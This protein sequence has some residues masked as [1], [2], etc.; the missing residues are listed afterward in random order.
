MIMDPFLILQQLSQLCSLNDDD[1]SSS[2]NAVNPLAALGLAVPPTI[3]TDT[4]S[5]GRP[6]R[7]VATAFENQTDLTIP[8][9]SW[10]LR[11][12]PRPTGTPGQVRVPITLVCH[13]DDQSFREIRI[14]LVRFELEADPNHL[15]AADMFTEPH[16]HLKPSPGST[17]VR[18][19]GPGVTLILSGSDLSDIDMDVT[20]A[21]GG[22]DP[23][24]PSARFE[25]PHFIIGGTGNN[26]GVACDEVLL[27]LNRNDN[28]AIVDDTLPGVDNTWR[29]LVLKELG[30]YIGDG[31]EVGTWSGMA[32]MKDFFIGFDAVDISGTFIAELVHYALENDPQVQVSIFFQNAAGQEQLETNSGDAAFEA[33]PEGRDF[34]RVRL[35][36]QPNWDSAGYRVNWVVPAGVTVEEPARRSSLN[37]GWVRVPADGQPYAFTVN[38]TDH[39]VPDQSETRQIQVAERAPGVG[40]QPLTVVFDGILD[41]P[42]FPAGQRPTN[43]LHLA[44]TPGQEATLT[45]RMGAGSGSVNATLTVPQGFTITTGAATQSATRPAGSNVYPDVQWVIR[46]PVAAPPNAQHAA[47]TLAVDDAGTIS[48]RRLRITF[49]APS[50]NGHRDFSLV[51]YTDWRA[52]AGTGQALV[53][54]RNGLAFADIAWTLESEPITSALFSDGAHDNLFN[55]ATY[56]NTEIAP[57]SYSAGT[58]RPYLGSDN[59]LYKLTGSVGAAPLTTPDRTPL[60]IGEPHNS[61]LINNPPQEIADFLGSL[62]S[63]DPYQ[64]SDG[65]TVRTIQ[66]HYDCWQ[67]QPPNEPGDCATEGPE[68]DG[69]RIEFPGDVN[70]EQAL[71]FAALFRAIDAHRDE[72]EAIGLF[73]G[74]SIEGSFTHNLNLAQNRV[75]AV[76]GALTNP[77][78]PLVDAMANLPGADSYTITPTVTAAIAALAPAGIIPK[79]FGE[80]R[81]KSPIDPAD[82]RVFAIF[83]LKGVP[84]TQEIVHTEYFVTLPGAPQP[85]ETPPTPQKKLQEHPF[86]HSIFRL[87]HVEV[88]LLRN[89]LV[90]LQIR[91]KLDLEAFNE[92]D[93][94]SLS[95]MRSRS[96]NDLDGVTTFFLEMKRNPE[97]QPGEPE[98][99]WEFVVLSDPGDVDGLTLLKKP[100]NETAVDIIGPPAIVTPALTA[101]RGGRIGISA[102]IAGV[103]VGAVLSAAGIIDAQVIVWRGIRFK[104]R[105]GSFDSQGI[106]LAVDYTVRYNIDANLGQMGNSPAMSNLPRLTTDPQ[107]PI[108]I[109]FRN[110]G[111]DFQPD[112]PNLE[113][114]YDPA[115]GFQLDV[116]DPGV[117]R[118][119]DGIGRLLSVDRVRGGAGSPLWLEVEL[120]LALETGIF[121]IDTLRIR[122]SLETDQLF[123][124]VGGEVTLGEDS[125]SVSDFD[126]SINKLG[127]SV[128]VPGT[129]EGRGELG[130]SGNDIEGEVDLSLVPLDLKIYAALK[131]LSLDEFRALYA[132]L[133]VE[134]APGIPM[135]TTGAAIYGFHG[136][137][138]VNMKRQN[139]DQPLEWLKA[140]PPGVTSPNKWDP[141]RGRWSFGVGAVIGT[142]YDTGFTFNTKGTFILEIPGPKF[143][144]AMES[145]FLAKKPGSE[146]GISG[147]LYSIIMLDFENDI[148]LIGIDFT[149]EKEN[150]ITFRVPTEVFFNLSQ[151]DDWHIRFGQWM[152]E[153]KRI[154]IRLFE[155]FN[156]WGYFVVEGN[157]IKIDDDFELQGICLATGSRIE[158]FWGSRSIGV[159]LEAYLE[160]HFGLQFD[161]LLLQG[162]IEV[163]GE[164]HLIVVSL[165]ARGKLRVIAPDPFV[166][167]GEICGK[168]DLWLF[169]IEGCASFT[170]GDGNATVPDPPDPFANMVL[171]DRMTS[172]AVPPPI[173]GGE[174]R[175]PLDA[176]LHLIFDYD[177]IDDRPDN[178]VNLS[179]PRPRNQISGDLFYDYKLTSVTITPSGGDALS[180]VQSA[181]APYTLDNA[182]ADQ[183]SSSRTLRLLDWKP[184][185]H[186]RAVDFS[187]GF[188]K[189]LELLFERICEPV[190]PPAS[191]CATFDEEAPGIRASWLLDQEELAPVYVIN[192]QGNGLGAERAGNLFS[193][194]AARVVPLVPIPYPDRQPVHRCLQLPSGGIENVIFLQDIIND[195]QNILFSDP[196]PQF[197]ELWQSGLLFIRL[198]DLVTAQVI[199]AL[200][201]ELSSDGQAVFLDQDLQPLSSIIS[202]QSLPVIPGSFGSG[203]FSAHAAKR[204][205]F[206]QALDV[207]EPRRASWLII[208][209]P[210]HEKIR[211]RN[212]YSYLLEICGIPY[213]EWRRWQDAVTGKASAVAALTNLTGVVGGIPAVSDNELLEPD[214]EYTVNGQVNWSRFREKNGA[215]DETGSHP[216][217]VRTFR[218]ADKAPD[219]IS[220]Y[221]LDTNPPDDKQPHYYEELLKIRFNS[222]IIDRLF[223]KFDKQLVVRA[224]AHKQS[225]VLNQPLSSGATREF[226]PLGSFEERLLNVLNDL[227]GICLPGDWETL[228]P[229]LVFTQSKP[230][231]ANTGYTVAVLP[232][233]LDELDP[234][235]PPTA[236]EW[237]RLLQQAFDLGDS[238]YRF[239][240]R[241]SRWPTFSAHVAAYR[242]PPAGD[243]F[244]ADDAA[245]TAAL[246][247]ISATRSDEAVDSLA[248]ALFGGPISLPR[249]PVT[250]RIWTETGPAADPFSPPP[251]RCRGILL[252]GPE[253][254]LK[255]LADGSPRVTLEAR[256][257]PAANTPFNSGTPLDGA[258]VI[259]GARGARIF[260]LFDTAS[261]PP[262]VQILLRDSELG[263]DERI[264]ISVGDTPGSFS[265]G[266]S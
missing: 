180:P 28:P 127:V 128:D 63:P 40:T 32:A 64:S 192:A 131:L 159:Y 65:T 259:V 112:G 187:S 4:A 183:A 176:L 13:T 34:M 225:H 174:P 248:V 86:R 104:L 53:R 228:F 67:I 224:K 148:F 24:F 11:L 172:A 194:S 153:S 83:K 39:R 168:L 3:T 117:F 109:T 79:H 77:Q 179:D 258:Q 57:S 142:V 49:A 93:L 206:D 197:A 165:S 146:G 52:D 38:I 101:L 36:A 245:L 211:D 250:A 103:S 207:D 185:A 209:A 242:D 99:I 249:A 147:G 59:H 81:A 150:L 237:D 175:A 204:L 223:A 23:E 251:F 186:E 21:A 161:P 97:P 114:F 184:N 213:S 134:F 196:S 264:V 94:P 106:S 254:L 85:K 56:T 100:E 241:T 37:L 61:D 205:I 261:P 116:N 138:G 46:A 188:G 182:D 129:L 170:I 31:K 26:L 80:D 208:R 190:P 7:L 22:A 125:I 149:F 235:D 155:L 51:S 195:L 132:A 47:A 191:A 246:S 10:K 231:I 144:L 84:A 156:A 164:L 70:R 108:E 41:D 227:S 198:P 255:L 74:A 133:G 162:E 107:N 118:L 253:P 27:D 263:I 238:V 92:N 214:T 119:G 44:M 202:F 115:D 158:I 212:P 215:V 96:L 256:Q 139:E 126:V 266:G 189:T 166:L 91:L 71:G 78:Q 29:G 58:V 151:P 55:G 88:E 1:L 265:E 201:L 123:E 5:D 233:D 68:D 42:D 240:I 30:V 163:G 220:R 48:N 60:I 111:V 178:A 216:P 113:F 232:R 230:L 17:L 35:Q 45:A 33:P 87:A 75:N 234:P 25:P 141:E 160:Y 140:N 219:N 18:L 152:P 72:I 262:F 66:F 105:Q 54:L 169:S 9:G 136:L 257:T 193:T 82:R 15:I 90:R 171:I 6:I 135:G 120:S 98:F 130:I 12:V 177:M 167:R 95:E 244:A 199:F 20:G 19:L 145:K 226:F 16:T 181:W 247:S 243:I 124:A 229:K 122:V 43:R 89:E 62:P 2:D 69:V 239:D 14:E 110:V 221:I 121:S 236:E 50:P 173:G 157:G 260:L 222:D 203:A 73:G 8:L 210:G 137:V 252:D 76:V 218:T 154:S 217:F 200:P 102:F 143:L